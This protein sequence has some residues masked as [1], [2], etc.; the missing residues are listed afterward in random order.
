MPR[1]QKKPW[2][3]GLNIHCKSIPPNISLQKWV[4]TVYSAH[5]YVF[6]GH[7]TLVKLARQKIKNSWLDLVGQ[8]L[9]WVSTHLKHSKNVV[10]VWI[11]TPIEGVILPCVSPMELCQVALYGT[12]AACKYNTTHPWLN[13]IPL[14]H[15]TSI[16]TCLKVTSQSTKAPFLLWNVTCIQVNVDF[17]WCLLWRAGGDPRVLQAPGKSSL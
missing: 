12:N 9:D 13:T 14:H 5:D 6:L 10:G 15:D 2:I 16:F 8:H 11:G 7:V 3:Y 1:N 4:Y 17:L